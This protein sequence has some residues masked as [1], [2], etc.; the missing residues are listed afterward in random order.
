MKLSKNHLTMNTDAVNPISAIN[1]NDDLRS[2]I[3]PIAGDS[4]IH[5]DNHEGH[6]RCPLSRR[7]LGGRKKGTTKQAKLESIRALKEAITEAS[8]EYLNAKTSAKKRKEKGT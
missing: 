1:L 5:S 6:P 3:S 2:A 7:N 8:D 4:G